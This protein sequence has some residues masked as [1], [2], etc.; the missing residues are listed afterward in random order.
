[1]V[2]TIRYRLST[3]HNSI[4]QRLLA[5]NPTDNNNRLIHNSIKQQTN[6]SL[7]LHKRLTT[8]TTKIL[9]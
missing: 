7:Q 1:M 9:P 3:E 4:Q 6:N 8:E 5:P 2:H